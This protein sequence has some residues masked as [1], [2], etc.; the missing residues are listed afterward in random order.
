MSKK[1]LSVYHRKQCHD[2]SYVM[3]TASIVDFKCHS[4]GIFEDLR[5]TLKVEASSPNTFA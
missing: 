2:T 1:D 4:C 3:F 5:F